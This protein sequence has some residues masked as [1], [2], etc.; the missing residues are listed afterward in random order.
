M[1]CAPTHH[2][3]TKKITQ[4]RPDLASQKYS[5][6]LLDR[7]NPDTYTFLNAIWDEFLPWFDTSQVHIGV[8]EYPVSEADKYRQFINIY[9]AYMRRKG[10]TIRM[11]GSLSEMKSNVQVNTDIV[12]DVWNNR[13]ANPVEMVKQGFQVINANDKLLYIVPKAGY[14]HDYLDTRLLYERWEP[15]I[16]DLS[17]P[18]LNL[19]PNDPHLSGGMFSEWNDKLGNIV[20]DADVYDRVKPAMQTLGEKL[21]NSRTPGMTYEQFEQVARKIGEAPG[22]HFP[23]TLSLS[24]NP[25]PRETQASTAAVTE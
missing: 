14:Y 16:F 13:W 11:W 7:D 23:Q 17:N 10:K 3:A 9:D 6:E 1:N 4:Y 8:D 24:S 25:L 2:T 21:W 20:S 18:S 22:T 12:V 19:Q 5:K 15:Y